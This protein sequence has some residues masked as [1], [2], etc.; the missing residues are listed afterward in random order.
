MRPPLR[1]EIP[2]KREV[3]A[4]Q[5]PTILRRASENIWDEIGRIETMGWQPGP[6]RKRENRGMQ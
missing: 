4:P 6:L 3:S 5:S 2:E 1:A